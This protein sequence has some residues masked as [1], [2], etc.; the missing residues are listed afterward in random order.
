MEQAFDEILQCV[1]CCLHS[2]ARKIGAETKGNMYLSL[3]NLS[4]AGRR[5]EIRAQKRISAV[6][7]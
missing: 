6:R 4:I 7:V 5:I 2:D 1:I 3:V